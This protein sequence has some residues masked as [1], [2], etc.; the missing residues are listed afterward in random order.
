MRVPQDHPFPARE[1]SSAMSNPFDLL[2]GA[3]P[4]VEDNVEAL[5]AAKPAVVKP[6][7]AVKGEDRPPTWAGAMRWASYHRSVSAALRRAVSDLLCQGHWTPPGPAGV[8]CAGR[9][10]GR[11]MPL[12]RQVGFA[13][14]VAA[15]GMSRV[16]RPCGAGA[17]TARP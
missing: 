12:T 9:G 1:P 7:A 13:R 8:H 10:S 15:P 17:A 2:G 5:A 11:T 3:D 16:R 14:D 6:A 4:D